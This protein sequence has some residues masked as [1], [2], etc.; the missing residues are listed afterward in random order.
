MRFWT[1]SVESLKNASW[2]EM[3]G[4][5][6]LPPPMVEATPEEMDRRLP[7]PILQRHMYD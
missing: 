4:K 7:V 5:E 3:T 6:I 1:I 2:L